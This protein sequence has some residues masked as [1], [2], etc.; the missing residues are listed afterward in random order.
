MPAGLVRE[1]LPDWLRDFGGKFKFI[2]ILS[3][4]V[5]KSGCHIPCSVTLGILPAKDTGISCLILSEC[6]DE[7]K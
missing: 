2:S 1:L 6:V 4:P 7:A 5:L 3:V